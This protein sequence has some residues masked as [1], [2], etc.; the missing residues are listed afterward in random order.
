MCMGAAVPLHSG[1]VP[2]RWC[3]L[4]EHYIALRRA[5]AYEDVL[6]LCRWAMRVFMAC[7]QVRSP[8]LARNTLTC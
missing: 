6:S 7:L 4:S 1:W 5:P 8:S 3:T 2:R